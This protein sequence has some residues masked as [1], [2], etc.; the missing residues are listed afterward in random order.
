M[1]NDNSLII[2]TKGRIINF[3]AK[4]INK[5]SIKI[6]VKLNNK[7]IKKITINKPQLYNIIKLN[8]DGQ[9]KLALTTRKNIAIY[10]FSF[11]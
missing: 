7:F 5:K 10:S 2:L 4:S 1:G 6:D 11:Q 8:P 9:K 3:V